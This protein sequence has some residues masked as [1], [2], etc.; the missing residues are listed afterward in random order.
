M[1][2]TAKE[3]HPE[4]IVKPKCKEEIEMENLKEIELTPEMMESISGGVLPDVVRT[5]IRLAKK[6]GYTLEEIKHKL[7]GYISRENVEE[8]LEAYWNSL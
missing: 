3:L 6:Q 2:I 8:E 7:Q 5:V 4:E 1:T